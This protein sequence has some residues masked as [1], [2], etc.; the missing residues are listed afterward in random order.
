MK[1]MMTKTER[2]AKYAEL[3]NRMQEIA[4]QEWAEMNKLQKALQVVNI[5][6]LVAGYFT[7]WYLTLAC[8]VYGIVKICEHGESYIYKVVNKIKKI[9]HPVDDPAKS[10]FDGIE[11]QI[12][13]CGNVVSAADLDEDDD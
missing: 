3:Q 5:F 1:N 7:M 10:K 6:M 9:M 11:H 2:A 12:E 4:D 8:I 13:N